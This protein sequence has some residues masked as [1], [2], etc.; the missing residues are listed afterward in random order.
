VRRGGKGGRGGRKGKAEGE[1]RR[2]VG[3][4]KG[5]ISLPHGRRKTLAGVAVI[6]EGY[7]RLPKAAEG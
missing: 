1:G 3:K 7:R 2:K 4:G 6:T 5:G